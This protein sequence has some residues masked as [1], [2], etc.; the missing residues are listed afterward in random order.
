[1][2]LELPA[3]ADIEQLKKQAKKLLKQYRQNDSD[4][5]SKVK[6]CHPRP[7]NFNGLRDAQL[8]IARLHG[9]SDWNQ[10][11]IAVEQAN[12]AAKSLT[13]RAELF[14][15]LGCTQYSGND[16]L[17]NYQRAQRLLEKFPDIAD[18][19]FYTALVA[20]NK[21]AVARNLELDPQKANSTGGPLDWPTLLYTTYSRVINPQD[22]RNSIDI[23]KMLLQCGSDPN[24]H[25]ILQ[26]TYRFTALTGALGEGEQGVNQP[27][28]PF[29]DEIA[30][31]LLSAGANPNDA[32][33]LYNT[34]F[35]SSG[36]KWLALLISHGLNTEHRLNAGT[37]AGD[38][39]QTTLDY[40]LGS[41]VNGNHQQRVDMLLNAG[42]NPNAINIYD[43]K[44]VHTNALLKGYTSVAD[45]L[46]LNGASPESLSVDD[47]FRLACSNNKVETIQFLLN[48]HPNLK[49]N[50][51][52]LHHAVSYGNSEIYRRLIDFGFDIN[53][54]EDNGRTVLHHFSLNND[55]NEVKYLLSRGAR[56]DIPDKSH[57]STAVGFAAYG[58]ANEVMHLLLDQSHNFLDVALCAYLKRATTLLDE[59]P[60]RAF[61]CTSAGN[62]AL[63]ILGM[64]LHEEPEYTA[65][66]NFVQL[67]LSAGL[68][69]N[70][71]NHQT[72]NPVQFHLA[73]GSDSMAELLIECGG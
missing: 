9:Y 40:Q 72:Q 44:T 59:N 47:E 5:F 36:D 54:Q 45:R 52:L 32:Q 14:I 27:A 29:A 13:E 3:Q 60:E 23:T 18:F 34:M 71:Q 56:F 19:S 22:A 57:Q 21:Q 68:D 15:R 61:E 67:L 11:S 35:T 1:M 7:Q 17:R 8:V 12:D 2:T 63:H 37:D 66:M 26:D 6:S 16:R 43:G 73:N 51:S 46:L 55:V 30:S 25:V 42:A 50:A 39:S 33:G 48:E 62:S 41:A 31:I 20:N 49:E 28:H 38:P 69:I 24:S 4:A 58:G 10:L 64:W 65:C 53:G 70:V